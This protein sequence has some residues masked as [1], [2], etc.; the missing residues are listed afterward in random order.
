M[1][2]CFME[3]V[4]SVTSQFFFFDMHGHIKQH[5]KLIQVCALIAIQKDK[6]INNLQCTQILIYIISKRIRMMN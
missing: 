1:H 6:T 4:F 2:K 3:L 5:N